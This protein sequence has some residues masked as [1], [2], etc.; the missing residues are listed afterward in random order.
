[1]QLVIFRMILYTDYS[2]LL[3]GIETMHISES[4]LNHVNCRLA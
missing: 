2:I 3:S 4:R 1:M